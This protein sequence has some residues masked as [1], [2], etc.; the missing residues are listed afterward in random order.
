MTPR[1]LTALSEGL[2]PVLREYA[3]VLEA[4]FA[5]LR[6]ANAALTARVAL[7]EALKV[8]AADPDTLTASAAV[9]VPGPPGPP[10]RDGRDGTNGR[11][12]KD[13]IDGKDGAPGRDGSDGRDGV[14]F[15]DLEAT[16]DPET[17]TLT[18]RYRLGDRMKTYAWVLPFLTDKGVYDRSVIYQT[19]DVVT[20]SGSM[21]V[22]KQDTQD[23]PGDGATAW[24]LCAKRGRDGKPGPPGPAGK[25][26]QD[27][28]PGKDLT[29]MDSTGRKW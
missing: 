13:G 21:W 7:L 1:E 5:A 18:H 15:D 17:K 10:G 9:G 11:D 6:A 27:G 14:G 25:D 16:L 4:Q 24:R 8:A 3:G 23:V 19:G 12:G 2:A 22:A 29:Q 28:R 26:G 20:H